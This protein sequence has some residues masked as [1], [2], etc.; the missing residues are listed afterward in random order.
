MW[1]VYI[2]LVVKSVYWKYNSLHRFYTLTCQLCICFSV[3]DIREG[4]FRYT[5]L[6]GWVIS[7][8]ISY[9]SA[10]MTWDLAW[11]KK[12]TSEKWSVLMLGEV[13]VWM[14]ALAVLFSWNLSMAS[15]RLMFNWSGPTLITSLLQLFRPGFRLEF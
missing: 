12:M 7:V 4:S 3:V 1:L 10:E 5:S 13:S 9:K 6:S 2:K 8:K 11:R 14:L 15:L